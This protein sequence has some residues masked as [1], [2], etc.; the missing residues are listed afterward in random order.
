MMKLIITEDQENDILKNVLFKLW[1]KNGKVILN[2]QIKKLF[3]VDDNKKWKL[4]NDF[5]IEWYE[6][7]G[8]DRLSP[9]KSEF[10]ELVKDKNGEIYSSRE[11][12]EF[13][14]KS[15]GYEFEI[16]TSF[17]LVD[18]DDSFLEYEY[19]FDMDK[20]KYNGEF[21]VRDAAYIMTDDDE[22]NN[23]VEDIRD[24]VIGMV[25]VFIYDKFVNPMGITDF[26]SVW[27]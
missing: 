3:H 8:V 14:I 7:R 19:Y 27:Y 5:V 21:I 11:G 20:L 2:R 25:N 6:T 24:D 16:E 22:F 18:L 4:V 17:I 23:Y 13:V 1:D 10:K 15:G 9:L 12:K 26:E